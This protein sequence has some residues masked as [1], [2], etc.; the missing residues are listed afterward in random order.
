MVV[1]IQLLPVPFINSLHSHLQGFI[2]LT[3]NS[4]HWRARK[5]TRRHPAFLFHWLTGLLLV[6]C[7][8]W[9]GDDC[10]GR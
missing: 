4:I 8:L 10:C 5:L 1:E 2:G 7:E 9:L 3:W 6:L